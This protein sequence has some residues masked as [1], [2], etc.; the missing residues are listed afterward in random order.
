MKKIAQKRN[1]K[2]LDINKLL[3]KMNKFKSHII[4]TFQL[5]NLSMAIAAAKL[6]NIKEQKIF[7]AIKS[8]NVVKGRLSC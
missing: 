2:I 8:I 6:C 7:K 5:K 3:E 4:G 1:L